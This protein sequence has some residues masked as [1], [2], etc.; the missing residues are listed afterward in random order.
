[1][2]IEDGVSYYNSF[3]AIKELIVGLHALNAF[4]SRANAVVELKYRH[5]DASYF[6]WLRPR[7]QKNVCENMTKR[8]MLI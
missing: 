6:Q 5:F 1:M 8:V 7:Y 2:K 4:K 3:P